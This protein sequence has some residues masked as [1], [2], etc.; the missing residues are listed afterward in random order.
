MPSCPIAM[1]SE[2]EMA[3]N[4]LGVHPESFT[5]AFECCAKSPRWILQ[6]VA[7]LQVE[8]TPTMGFDKSSSF[9]P[10]AL[11]I[12]LWGALAGPLTTVLLTSSISEVE[13]NAYFNITLILA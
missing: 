6:G 10:M 11:Y 13:I 1:P 12:A 2:T 5:P 8:E 3:V 7:S 4:S 9:K